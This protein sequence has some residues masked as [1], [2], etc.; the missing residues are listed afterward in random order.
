MDIIKIDIK[1]IPRSSIFDK[2]Y[3]KSI[4]LATFLCNDILFCRNETYIW[5]E[6]IKRWVRSNM[7]KTKKIMITRLEKYYSKYSKKHIPPFNEIFKRLK[8]DSIIFNDMKNKC[9]TGNNII[10]DRNIKTHRNIQKEDYL[11]INIY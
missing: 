7:I 6:E 11:L 9:F 4:D 5:V 8:N 3:E 10:Y 1:D 2:I